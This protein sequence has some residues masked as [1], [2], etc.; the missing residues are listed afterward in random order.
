M[1]GR[2]L[3]IATPEAVAVAF[4]CAV[5]WLVPRYNIAPSQPIA[6]VRMGR[7]RRELAL[8]RWGFVPGWARDPQRFRPVAN[9]RAEGLADKPAFRG[10]LRY[11]RCLVPASGWYQWERAAHGR[12]RPWLIRPRDG[13]V[14]GLAGLWEPWL[15]ADGSEVDGAAMVTLAAGADIAG[16]ADRMPAV[17]PPA[18]YERWLDVDRTSVAAAADLLRPADPGSLEAVPVD[19][20]VNRAGNDDPDLIPA[21]GGGAVRP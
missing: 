5:D 4:G 17:I 1:S 7:G 16:I 6:V 19:E 9:A 11:R 21:P 15:G 8:V 3:L 12:S 2:F 10:A 14:V 20:R 13:G 18:A